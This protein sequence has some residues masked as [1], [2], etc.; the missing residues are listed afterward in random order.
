LTY[1][2]LEEDLATLVDLS[3]TSLVILYFNNVIEANIKEIIRVNANCIDLANSLAGAIIIKLL[4]I[5]V[6]NLNSKL[7]TLHLLS[8]LSQ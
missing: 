4:L 7:F 8:Y 1:K 2:Y 6:L 3:T 5:K